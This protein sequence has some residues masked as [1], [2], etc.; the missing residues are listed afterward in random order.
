MSYTEAEKKELD[1]VRRVNPKFCV[2][3]ISGANRAKLIC[4]GSRLVRL[5]PCWHHNAGGGGC[6]G[7]RSRSEVLPKSWTKVMRQS[8]FEFCIGQDL[9]HSIFL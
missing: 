7:R 8:H 1:K 9:T 6:Q 4:G 2:K 5:P 3:S